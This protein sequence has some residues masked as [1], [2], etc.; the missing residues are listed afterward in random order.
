MSKNCQ[1][2]FS[3]FY[4][5]SVKW[6]RMARIAQ[7]EATREPFYL[8]HYLQRGGGVHAFGYLRMIRLV[9]FWDDTTGDTG[10]YPAKKVSY[11][12]ETLPHIPLDGTI[13]D[14]TWDKPTL[15]TALKR[16][17]SSR[18]TDPE[19]HLKAHGATL[20]SPL[21]MDGFQIRQTILA[22]AEAR[23]NKNT[24]VRYGE[25]VAAM[26]QGARKHAEKLGGHTF[27]T[28]AHEIKKA[29]DRKRYEKR[30]ATIEQKNLSVEFP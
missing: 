6:G 11:A 3:F 28:T 12:V 23:E 15:I 22:I 4:K 7:V 27:K 19:E 9:Q 20:E 30:R 24:Q 5:K 17:A 14:H 18:Y 29:R 13:F 2:S 26:F 16:G 21:K 25:E 8:I 1:F 10:F